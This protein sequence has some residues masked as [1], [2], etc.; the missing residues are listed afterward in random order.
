[1]TA[2]DLFVAAILGLVEG[3][4]E[5]LP[6]S[7]TGHL[8]VA[9]SLLNYTGERAKLFEI[10]I[11]A[12]AIVAVCWEYRGQALDGGARA[13]ERAPGTALRAEPFDRIPARRRAGTRVRRSDQGTAVR[14]GAG[15]RGLHRRR[16]GHP[17]GGAAAALEARQ[18][19]HPQRRRVALDRRAEDRP[20]AGVRTDP[21]DVAFRSD[22]H[23][24]D[25]VRP[26]AA[27]GHRV[28]VLPR[29]SHAVRRHRLRVRQESPSAG[30]R[31][32]VDDRR[33]FRRRLRQRVF[34]HSSAGC[35]VT[36]RITISSRSRG[37]ASPSDW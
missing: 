26:V 27:G 14:A 22:D 23:R 13:F 19:A 33:R 25:A 37:T 18:R 24:R 36:S 35:C 28:L 8:I 32:P 34:H 7:S 29:H 3:L 21:G 1:M 15:R 10:V 6:V 12:G 30:E 16:A 5:F 20:R 31:R 2:P 9:G 4:T 11:Q 17:L